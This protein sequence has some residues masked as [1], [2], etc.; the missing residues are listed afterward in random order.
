MKIVKPQRL[1]LLTRTFEDGPKSYLV[2]S[3]V[4]FF[5]FSLPEYLLPEISLWKMIPKELGAEGIFD[6]GMPKT[7]GEAL[8]F[9]KA[10]PKGG[11]APSTYVRLTMGSIQ[12]T[13][14]V[15]GAR[16]FRMGVATAPE[17]F[18]EMPLT[19]DNSYGGPGFAK[20]PLGKGHKPVKTDAGEVHSLPHVEDPKHLITSPSDKPEPVGFWPIDLTW[21]QR[22][23]HVGTYDDR[24]LKQRYPG[25]PEDFHWD[26]WS[27]A[28]PDQ[29]IAGFFEASQSFKLEN[30][31]PSKPML[32]GHLPAYTARCFIVC[33]KPVPGA[34]P[35]AAPRE[36]SPTDLRDVPTRIDT[37]LFFPHLER[38]AVIY[39][40]VVEVEEDDARD[41]AFI[42]AGV[43]RLKEPKPIEHYARV[44]TDR[45][46]RKKPFAFARE[47][48]LLPADLPKAGQLFADD[49]VSD[50]EELLKLEGFLQINARRGAERR[51][52][53]VRKELKERGINPDVV[54]GL[55]PAPPVPTVEELP[56][57]FEHLEAEA[58]RLQ[59]EAEKQ[60]AEA[61]VEIRKLC[62]KS[63]VDFDKILAGQTPSQQRRPARFTARAELDRLLSM[64]K[65]ADNAGASIP[66]LNEKLADPTLTKK[67]IAVEE[68][69]FDVL[70][71]FAHHL[72]PPEDQVVN[73][74]AEILE[75]RNDN[76]QVT[77]LSFAGRDLTD[78]D[79]SG[80]NLSGCDFE[81][82][83]LERVNF[84]GCNL[85]GARLNNAILTRSNLS[86][87]DLTGA[88]CKGANFG[89]TNLE[90]AN[91]SGTDLTEAVLGKANLTGASFERAN[92]KGADL[93]EAVLE[94]TNFASAALPQ[95]RFLKATLKNVHFENA[96][97]SQAV[98]IEGTLTDV[99]FSGSNLTSAV[100]LTTVGTGVRF[101]KAKL[102]NA[103]FVNDA[104]FVGADFSGVHAPT[105]N[106]R[107]A[108]LQNS[109][110]DGAFVERSDLSEANL[111]GAN[112]RG[113]RAREALFLRTH[114]KGANMEGADLM[115]ALL[116]KAHVQGTKLRH[117]S[118]FRADTAKMRGDKQTDLTG[119][120]VLHA[121][122]VPDRRSDG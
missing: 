30:M 42:V 106:F 26:F 113:L 11:A 49:K 24:W 9:G 8:V 81:E 87:A 5:P 95:C 37:V 67:L 80:L 17:P 109:V 115:M 40:G 117:A 62:A 7:R 100:F 51:L 60:R 46:D 110:W 13:L 85:Q 88:R 36:F 105:S 48:E 76:G 59:K 43:E 77:A 20:N 122:V 39:R 31:H 1:S 68:G 120:N 32:E 79:L 69:L 103:R 64:K 121:R 97:L 90:G 55:P 65:L 57:V 84:E 47:S 96:D 114:L 94:N 56:E 44:L 102:E 83:I 66:V 29:R 50:M 58:A 75:A 10:Y 23:K 34:S 108:N 89:L 116:Q 6:E 15:L 18:N 41:V 63:G 52:E 25:Y 22:Q 54:P 38:A 2:V 91:L 14:Y 93:M 86:K 101:S 107:G 82:A 112:L 33:Q 111:E 73:I 16:R 3:A 28:P 53:D 12:K 70:R 74:K 45:L 35:V 72:P 118:L 119:A 27:V 4:T 104:S 71:R 19:W 78:G 98:F 92:L 61:E 21:P 99:D